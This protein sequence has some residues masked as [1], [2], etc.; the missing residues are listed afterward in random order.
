MRLLERADLA[1][2]RAWPS[3]VPN[4]SSS[5]RSGAMAAAL[6]TTNG[7]SV[8]VRLGVHHARH[9]LLAGARRRRVISTRLLVGATLSIG[10]AQLV[11]G[12][13]AGRSSRS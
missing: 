1:R 10:L 5:T 13:R 4:S 7:P 12:R 6:S 3:S 8:R 2:A 11:D 9:Q